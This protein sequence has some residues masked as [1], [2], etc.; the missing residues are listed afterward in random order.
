MATQHPHMSDHEGYE[1]FRNAIV[2]GSGDAWAQIY[3]YYRPLL[4]GWSRQC[5]AKAASQEP[6]EDIA[7]LAF[8]RAWSALSPEHFSDFYSLA[9]LLAYLRSCVSAAVIDASRAAA[10]R[11]RAY[12]RLECPPVAT[13]EQEVMRQSLQ[14]TFW[15]LIAS[16]VASEQERVVLDE[17]F[18]LALPPRQIYANH[19][20]LFDNVDA[21][22][23]IKRNLLSRLE[24][25][26]ALRRLYEDLRA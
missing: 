18:L 8:S 7:D 5:C 19:T 4:L 21:V 3:T 11:Q 23:A 16:I 9:S 12:Q 1:L 24:R 14:R 15:S 13:P 22:Y 2:G 17:T 20:N 25:S 10:T 6:A 26:H